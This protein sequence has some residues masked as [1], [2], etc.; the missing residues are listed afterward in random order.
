[1][2]KI[3]LVILITI[4]LISAYLVFKPKKLVENTSS[5]QTPTQGIT[6]TSSIQF[7]DINTNGF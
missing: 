3:S 6:Q 2:K 4:I 5:A 1:M 7:G